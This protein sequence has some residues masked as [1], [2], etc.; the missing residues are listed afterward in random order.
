MSLFA[1]LLGCSLAAQGQAFTADGSRVSAEGRSAAGLAARFRAYDHLRSVHYDVDGQGTHWVRGRGYKACADAKGFSFTPFLGSGVP[2]NFPVRMRLAEAMCGDESLGLDDR[3]S[4]HREASRIE[5]NRG[6][7]RVRY[8]CSEHG[9]EQSFELETASGEGD[10]VLFLEV[11]TELAFAETADGFRFS[12]ERGGVDY[13]RATVLDAAGKSAPVDAAWS[14]GEIQLTVP[15]SFL[16][17]AAWPIVVDPLLTPFTVGMGAADLS[18]PDAAYDRVVE[19]YCVVFEEQFSQ[20]DT[21]LFTYYVAFDMS[22]TDGAYLDQSAASWSAPRVMTSP[23]S[24]RAL[25]VA[26]AD[27]VAVPGSKDIGGRSRLTDGTLEAPFVVKSAEPS[28]SCAAPAVG[29]D[30]DI[31]GFE[32]FLVAYNRVTA[33]TR[34]VYSISL[35]GTQPGSE[36][37][38]AV[39]VVAEPPAVSSTSGLCCGALN[40][41]VAWSER[42]IP[43][44]EFR[45]KAA[46]VFF[47]GMASPSFTVAGPSTDAFY[48]DVDVS[49]GSQQAAPGS[50]FVYLVTYDDRPSSD[51]DSFVAV[52]SEG[53][54]HNTYQLQLSEHADLTPNQNDLSIAM[55]ND[56]FM[57]GYEEDG[58][59]ILT[60][61]ETVDQQLS[62]AER[63]SVAA[64]ANL[65]PG[66]LA[67]AGALQFSGVLRPGLFVWTELGSSSSSI[68]GSWATVVG[69]HPFAAGVQYCYGT[70]N[71]TGDRGFIQVTGD[72]FVGGHHELR[73]EALPPNVFGYFLA[74]LT[75][76]DLPGAG[77]SLGTL[78]VSGNVGRFGVFQADGQGSGA[79]TLD[80]LQII[81]PQGPV[82]ALPLE[83]WN[84]QCWYR[85]AVGG[86]A[87]SNFTNAVTVP[88]R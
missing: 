80:T 87:V 59:L 30:G 71:S 4:V 34:D 18:R 3:A 9:V 73:V 19:R 31:G 17:S 65:V 85:D 11:E 35:I 15:E 6:A 10:L 64:G 49:P 52:C 42:E 40:Y 77:G 46:Q 51:T 70:P 44:G 54:V 24:G 82:A 67:G 78:C 53:T 58:Q 55:G 38:H 75:P 41:Q 47:T 20:T 1:L 69:P 79:Q 2:R 29:A 27:S 68:G 37:A 60:T 36:T 76:G 33:T 12:N 61:V 86:V 81:Q 83:H 74:S 62:I 84:F 72:R 26:E 13:G 45:V 48:F 57:L 25:Y 16:R 63:R 66:S 39:G 21:D 88:F 22:L 7:V 8:D 14:A 56:Q 5:L 32:F 28:F 43:T 50:G 23:F